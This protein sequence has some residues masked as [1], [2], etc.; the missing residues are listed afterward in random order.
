MRSGALKIALIYIV[1][2]FVWIAVSDKIV[3]ATGA[4]LGSAFVMYVS[5]LKGFAYVFVTGIVL[6]KLINNNAKRLVVSEKKYRGYFTGNPN[7]MWVYNRKTYRFIDINNAACFHYGYTREEFLSMTILDIR[8]PEDTQK[9]LDEVSV[10]R[11]AFKNSGIWRHQKKNGELMF[12]NVTSHVIDEAG[13]NNVIVM[14]VDMTERLQLE[15]ERNDY[16]LKLE[17]IQNSISDAFFTLDDNWIIRSVNTSFENITGFKRE[18]ALNRNLL[19]VWPQRIDSARYINYKKVLAENVTVKF[20]DYSRLMEK[21]LR[22]TCYPTKEG[23][24]IY[25]TDITESKEKDILLQ[26]ALERYD[27]A[28]K[29]TQDL[30]YDY[31]IVNNKLLYSESFGKLANISMLYEA[32]PTHSWL[33]MVH[34]DDVPKLTA[35]YARSL[36]NSAVKHE[37][38][39]R[40]NIGN[41]VYRYVNDQANIIY[42][43]G[44]AVRMTGAI[45]DIHELTE[46]NEENKRL[47]KIINSVNNLV[48]ITNTCKKVVWVNRAFEE[49]TGYTFAEMKGQ[50]PSKF[51]GGPDPDPE[52]IEIITEYAN[53]NEKFSMELLS[54]NREGKQRWVYADFTP[55]FDDNKHYTGYITIYTD[56]S[57]VKEKEASLSKQHNIMREIAWLGSHELRRPLA[58]ILGLVN[59]LKLS[60]TESEHKQ[61][62]DLLD[63][64]SNEL[65]TMVRKINANISEVTIDAKIDQSV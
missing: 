33:N 10:L 25:F 54:V 7:P 39:Y 53:R 61:F 21:W 65:D 47:G 34:P 46:S 17:D 18:D 45:R 50:T 42:E 63:I 5:S 52:N 58:S 35:T 30:F 6:Y 43:N 59:L 11:T 19:D 13:G 23:A 57:S 29:A 36:A 12:V 26:K 3:F 56:I 31:D 41:G 55:L 4:A 62:I 28:A 20:E 40:L 22:F 44:Q 48:M 15:R 9:V 49:F 38:D 2:G 32:D 51:I 24:A 14:A 60:N 8:P 37:C 64:S 1:A 16:L 27:L